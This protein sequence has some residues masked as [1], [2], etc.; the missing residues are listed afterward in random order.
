[1]L[2]S[3]TSSSLLAQVAFSDWI[4]SSGQKG[5][6][7]VNAMVCDSS[8][9][10]FLTGSNT[11]SVKTGK[12][13]NLSTSNRKFDFL[14]KY[15]SSG[16]LLWTKKIRASTPGY[17]SL[18]ATASGGRIILAGAFDPSPKNGKSEI[19]KSEF[20]LCGFD[21]DGKPEWMQTFSGSKFDYFTS[22][23]VNP[24]TN[25]ILLSGYF[26]DSLIVQNRNFVSS[27][28]ADAIFLRFDSGGKLETFNQAGGKGDDRI[29][30][31]S[32]DP[33]GNIFVTGTFQKKI[34]LGENILFE[35]PYQGETGMF[36]AQY[37]PTGEPVIAKQTCSAKN[38]MVSS[39][40]AN[41]SLL[42]VYGSFKD[43]LNIDGRKI[44]S[45][46]SDDV[47]VACMDHNL[48][49][50]WVKQIGGVR[51]DRAC[52]ISVDRQRVILSGSFCS[53]LFADD[54]SIKSNKE[55]SD[56]FILSLDISGRIKWIRQMGGKNDD[57]PKGMRTTKEHYIYIAGSYRD[58]LNI[59]DKSIHS[60]GE[61][62]I[63]IGRIEDCSE[64]APPFK[65][66]ETFCFGKA[67]TLDGGNGFEAY[68]WDNGMSRERLYP[69]DEGG[70]YTLERVHRNGCILYDTVEVKEN[71]T[72]E[73]FIGNDTT[74]SDTSF[75]VLRVLAKHKEYAW[76]NGRKDAVNVIRGFDLAEGKNT[77]W[78]QVTDSNG[79]QG[80]DEMVVTLKKTTI[81]AASQSL[82][83]ACTIYPNPTSDEVTVEF[84][85]DLENL[86]LKVLNQ[87]GIELAT[88]EI[89][90]YSAGAKIRFRLGAFSPGIYT[91]TVKNSNAFAIK[92][93]VVQ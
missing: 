57:Y 48:N 90:R 41:D 67:L 36:V 26:Y 18:I 5:W 68:N 9:N 25:H 93:I 81:S 52:E 38:I 47:F 28:K 12:T 43:F 17:G 76:S 87:I 42:F 46:G 88:K 6:D 70:L 75:L 49:I 61:E 16:N 20:F 3:V 30:S 56:I 86:K 58:T 37:A 11:D 33:I 15:D 13:G 71:S 74:I 7:I 44:P 39:T 4:V 85:C 69:V 78:L 54:I 89:N 50:R 82:L 32:T 83:N 59:G 8:G 77:I 35:V 55:S 60:Q 92:K 31:I 84:T 73:I 40:A 14:A 24:V 21:K 65:K 27:G 72:P 1:M 80:Y 91:I 64:L 51:K 34:R 45:R 23:A 2:F 62:D 22:L 29:A 66:P 53:Q 19:K 63:F 79:C 10:I